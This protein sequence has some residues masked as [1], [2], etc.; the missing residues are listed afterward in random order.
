MKEIVMKHKSAVI[1]ALALV[2]LAGAGVLYSQ[3]KSRSSATQQ[4]KVAALMG[5]HDR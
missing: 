5:V 4:E 2:V 3:Q 1:A